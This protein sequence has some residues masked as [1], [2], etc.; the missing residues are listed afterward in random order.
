MGLGWFGAPEHNRWLAAETHALLRYGRAAKV[1]AGFG[2]IGE[3]GAVD[4]SHPVE[5]W[6]T[7]RMT[8]AFSLGTLMGIPGCRRFADHGVRALSRV[9]RDHEHGGWY[10]AVGHELDAEGHGVP[11]DAQAHK[12]CYQHAFVLLAAATAK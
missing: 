8:F 12:E 11:V 3:D 10:S 6:I 5:L 7:G 2:W 1:P 4:A 9:M